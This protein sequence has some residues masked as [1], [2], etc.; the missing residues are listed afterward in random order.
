[1]RSLL[2]AWVGSLKTSSH[3]LPFSVLTLCLAAYLSLWCSLSPV[4]LL[5]SSFFISPP[6][7]F[8]FSLLHHSSLYSCFHSPFISCH[9]SCSMLFYFTPPLLSFVSFPPFL[10]QSAYSYCHPPSSHTLYIFFTYLPPLL[11]SLSSSS[12]PGWSEYVI[13][14]AFSESEGAGASEGGG[15]GGVRRSYSR[16]GTDPQQ[17]ALYRQCWYGHTHFKS[18]LDIEMSI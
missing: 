14:P 7:C 2:V 11:L 3:H 18:D 12:P 16:G 1:M 17:Q 10:L 5:I 4:F 13:P 6:A 8:L 9:V 15:A